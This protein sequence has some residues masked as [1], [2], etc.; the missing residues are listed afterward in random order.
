MSIDRLDL[1]KR[2][3]HKLLVALLLLALV[4]FVVLG[5]A[6]WFSGRA[7]IF[8]TVMLAGIMGAFVSL[9]RR[10]KRL[11]NNDLRLLAESP[12]YPWLSPLAGGMLASVLYLLFL[13]GLLAGTLF[14]HFEPDKSLSAEAH[15]L[16]RLLHMYSDNPEEYAKLL[17]WSFVAGFSEKFVVDI[18]GRFEQRA[19][20]E[21]P[22]A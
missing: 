12:L 2:I 11:P 19:I 1:V 9:Q 7:F 16:V 8:P 15:G 4:M 13:S 22:D 17:F 3:S 10:L 18:I 14:P 21:E 5:V 6:L 20:Q